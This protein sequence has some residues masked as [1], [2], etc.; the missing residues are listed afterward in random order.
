[1]VVFTTLVLSVIAIVNR[2]NSTQAHVH[3]NTF[4]AHGGFGLF[5]RVVVYLIGK[6]RYLIRLRLSPVDGIKDTAHDT[7]MPDRLPFFVGVI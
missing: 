4:T 7:T 1:M 5:Y 6:L 2:D 3:A